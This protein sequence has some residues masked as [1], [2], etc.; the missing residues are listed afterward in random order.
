MA[1]VQFGLTEKQIALV[2]C[3]KGGV[4][5]DIELTQKETEARGDLQRVLDESVVPL[6]K[7]IY[8]MTKD[9][10][11]PPDP[12]ATAQNFLT[13]FSSGN[14]EQVEAAKN[15]LLIDAEKSEDTTLVKQIEDIVASAV[16]S[17]QFVVDIM[18][19]RAKLH[20]DT[21]AEARRLHDDGAD[22]VPILKAA[23][24]LGA[25]G[26]KLYAPALFYAS[27]HPE[28]QMAYAGHTHLVDFYTD[29]HGTVEMS[30]NMTTVAAI[31]QQEGHNLPVA[32]FPVD[33]ASLKMSTMQER[34]IL[35]DIAIRIGMEIPDKPAIGVGYGLGSSG[36]DA[37]E[38]SFLTQKMRPDSIGG[39]GSKK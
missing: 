22:F 2:D 37:V 7:V 13:H 15:F 25:A 31:L 17:T 4:E 29:A 11:P 26:N 20:N 28:M 19:E 8:A 39:P 14:P 30:K 16:H 3:F 5:K 24:E 21:F 38:K 34:F 33:P 23:V 18:N 9:L 35:E 12:V 1:D 6:A 36:M 32:F 10:D 27:T